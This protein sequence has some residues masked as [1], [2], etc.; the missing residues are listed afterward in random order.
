M[1]YQI[2]CEFVALLTKIWPKILIFT[3]TAKCWREGCYAPPPSSHQD[4][5][6]VI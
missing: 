6:D 1:E 4:V 3:F 2:I 5:I